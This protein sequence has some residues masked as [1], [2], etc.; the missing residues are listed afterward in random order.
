MRSLRPLDRNTI[1]KSVKKTSRLVSVEE[2]WP[3]CGI[4]A[5]IC[6][7]IMESEAFDYIDAPVERV[8]GV[9]VP[10]PYSISIE[11]KAIPQVENIVNSVLR[12]CYRQK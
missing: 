12:A 3:Q 5:E 8:T 9:D 1:I 2:G 11:Q 10:M 6:G 4:G 7:L